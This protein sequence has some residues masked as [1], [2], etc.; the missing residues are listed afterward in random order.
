MKPAKPSA[1]VAQVGD[2][3]ENS[4]AAAPRQQPNIAPAPAAVAVPPV[5]AVPEKGPAAPPALAVPEATDHV[6]EDPSPGSAQP[7][8]RQKGAVGVAI[9]R[10]HAAAGPSAA[11]ADNPKFLIVDP[12]C[13]RELSNEY[14]DD[15]VPAA[16]F[17]HCGT[18]LV[19]KLVGTGQDTGINAVVEM[20]DDCWK[21][22]DTMQTDHWLKLVFREPRGETKTRK[23]KGSRSWE[24]KLLL[25]YGGEQLEQQ[26]WDQLATLVECT[27]RASLAASNPRA[28]EANCKHPGVEV[29]CKFRM[30]DGGKGC[31][32]CGDGPRVNLSHGDDEQLRPFRR[33]V[34][35]L[36]SVLML[37]WHSQHKQKHPALQQIAEQYN[38]KPEKPVVAPLQ[39]TRTQ[40]GQ[41]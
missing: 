10:Q 31:K 25:N 16:Y 39:Q 15:H 5:A 13:L 40:L 22:L 1:A 2:A 27:K 20:G 38:L 6:H 8:R 3:A 24:A 11:A 36:T 18:Q 9:P 4:D 28:F 29:E 23:E 41:M 26:Q 21:A 14:G 30:K 32:S 12:A 7:S 17:L 35:G 37:L 33:A 34:F 19:G